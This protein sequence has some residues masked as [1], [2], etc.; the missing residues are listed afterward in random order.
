MANQT[1]AQIPGYPQY[2]CNRDR[3]RVGVEIKQH[4]GLTRQ[5]ISGCFWLQNE[6]GEIDRLL[7]DDIYRAVFYNGELIPQA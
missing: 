4:Q 7:P 6:H 1:W 5:T 3:S 2:L